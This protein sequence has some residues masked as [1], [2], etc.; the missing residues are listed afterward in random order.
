[1][2][3]E[4]GFQEETFTEEA[5]VGTS[6]HI[7]GG[8]Q[9]TKFN[10]TRN[11]CINS[12]QQ[13]DMLH[14]FCANANGLKNK[15][16]SLKSNINKLKIGIF[17]VQETNFVKKG[18]LKV[19]GF[20]IFESI[21]KKSGG[22]T[23]LGAHKDLKP[24]LIEEYSEEFELVVI[25]VSVVGK[26]I[27][28]MTGYGPQETW[29]SE[30]RMPFF[31]TLEEEITMAE[32]AGRS[33]LICM[34]ANSK[35]GPQ[36]I[37]EDPHTISEN[38]RVLEGILERHAL[39]VANG[40]RGKFSGVITR[41]R[42][43]KDHKEQS[44]IDLVCISQD[45]IEELS[46]ISID[47][48]KVYCLESIR[49]TKK[50]IQTSKSDHNSIISR[51][52][53][54]LE[55]SV[56]IARIER[57]DLKNKEAQ[58]MFTQLTSEKGA[59]TS[60]V[61][62]SKDVNTATKKFLKR[63]NG[64]ISQSFKK[65][66]FSEHS[67]DTEITKLFDERRNL[68]QK[69]DKE[70]INR[71]NIVE[72]TL[73]DKC[74]EANMRIIED[75]LKDFECDEGGFNMGKLW[76]L[77]KRLCPYRKTPPTA[78]SDPHGNLITCSKNLKTHTVEHYKSV[79]SNR[80]IKEGF[81]QLKSDKEELSRLRLEAAKLNKSIPWTLDDLEEV[82]K[83]LKKD[84]CRDPN[85][86]INELFHTKVAGSD[87]K[88]AVLILMNR[89]KDD[90]VYPEDLERCN[91]TSIYKKGKK[92]VFDN[93]RGVFRV[94]ILR[95]IL[96]RLVYNDVYPKID[97]SL[98]DAN[99][100]CR[101]GRN[102][103]D[104]L[105]VVNAVINS[106]T[107]GSTDS[108]DIAVY[109]IIKAFDSLW[110]EECINDLFDAGCDDDKLALIQLG[111][112][113]AQVA[114]NTSE[115]I[116]DRINILN[117]IMQGTVSGGLMCTTSVDKLTQ[118]AYKTKNLLYM[119]K[120]VAVPPLGMV[121][122]ILTISQ[123]SPQAIAMNATVNSFVESKKLKLKQSKCSVI[124]VGKK[125]KCNELKVHGEKMHNTDSAVYLGDMIHKSGKSKFNIN[126]R[127]IKGYAIMAEIRAILQ[128]VPLGKYKTKVG[129]QLRQAM[130]VNGILFNS[131][132]WNTISQEDMKK[133]EAIDHQVMRVICG[134]HAK[135]AIEYLYLET[136]EKP[137]RH[138]ITNRRLM[139]LRHILQKEDKELVKRI[140]RAQQNDTTSGDFIDQIRKDFELIGE[141]YC[142]ETIMKQTKNEFKIYIK[143]K[144]N[145]VALKYLQNLQQGHSKTKHMKY[146]KLQIQPYIESPKFNNKLVSLLF[147]MKNSMT[148]EI[149]N[150]FSSM[151]SGDNLCPM[152]CS[153]NPPLDT[154]SHI[155]DCPTLVG[156]LTQD[157][158]TAA[159]GVEYNH[160]YGSLEEQRVVILIL[161]KL[162][163]IREELLED[164]AREGS[165]PVGTTGPKIST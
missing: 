114:I 97:E 136:G 71:L 149:K 151:N 38:G 158:K 39:T 69:T 152:Q 87:M 147:N 55:K 16:E 154:Q 57:F 104:N 89:I 61:R 17:T 125:S 86:H 164:R 108:C 70:S 98:S 25:E 102:I 6:N 80:P 113:N 33:I 103:R 116:T 31:M 121:D 145:D 36:H 7:N 129:L 37:P 88:E 2:R 66:R 81:E 163:D 47:E 165:L 153:E 48:E 50:G 107:K 58:E 34:D 160:I 44:A 21:R 106:V 23:I 94:T 32:L 15:V 8:P 82:L 74:A 10:K 60:L 131:E 40:I 93:Y 124:H 139:Y 161:A 1:M 144:V 159:I 30:Q 4:G 56:K 118:L 68:R 146:E 54:E 11:K 24:I 42:T 110:A 123:C 119:Y 14:V 138:I 18:K 133:M 120:G 45:L 156:K 22:G 64:F 128:D 132:I 51:F 13:S 43:T 85:D 72:E 77:K 52:N 126:E 90:L 35:M 101:K 29:S 127:C 65:I 141:Q 49:R 95:N 99:V 155:L 53:I 62:K 75:E 148:K 78:M 143:N 135:T 157:E 109:D 140:F 111:T 105:F 12:K 91:I 142:E 26:V 28:V 112:Q 19:E 150:N 96:D 27:R 3:P 20:E 100:G 76:K 9:T 41:A 84:K 134:A 115:G 59:M 73:A 92:N 5:I 137:L 79:L 122:D 63:L 67:G 46:S 162:L 83:Y 130:F 117:I